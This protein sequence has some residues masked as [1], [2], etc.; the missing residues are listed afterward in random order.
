M[1]GKLPETD[2]S[3]RES[4]DGAS[5]RPRVFISYSHDSEPHAERVLQLGERLRRDG[6]D[7]C[8]DRYVSGTPPQGW[9]RWMLD[10]LDWASFVLVVCS[11]T[12]YRRFRGHEEQRGKGADWE[13]ALITSEIY[14]ARSDTKKFV[15]VLFEPGDRCIPEPIQGHTHH[16]LIT[17]LSYQAL[18]DFLLGQAGVVPGPLGELRRRPQRRGNPMAFREESAG[19]DV[20][21]SNNVAPSSAG[22]RRAAARHSG[23]GSAPYQ[24]LSGADAIREVLSNAQCEAWTELAFLGP[25]WGDHFTRQLVKAGW[26]HDRIFVVMEP[27]GDAVLERLLVPLPS[28]R[29]LTLSR[30]GLTL[31]RPA[32]EWI[33][34]WPSLTA[35]DVSYN[36]IGAEG[37][38]AI[39]SSFRN[40]TTLELQFNAIGAD[41]AKAIASFLH[42][43]AFLD[44][45]F[46]SVGSEGVKS[47][48]SSLHNLTSLNL[49]FNSVD[50]EGAK[51]IASSLRNLISLDLS[52]NTV[53]VEGARAIASSLRNLTSL[54][55][56]SN[57][58]GSDG[59][60]AIASSLPNLTS[61]GLSNNSV[62]SGGARAIASSLRNL[63]SLELSNNSIS[64]DGA[65]SI[66]SS[67][68]NLA[69]LNLSYNSVAS[70]GAKAIASSLQY[71]TSLNLSN[72]RVGFDGAKSIAS[73]LHNLTYLNLANNPITPDGAKT[74]ASSL[75][76]L[77]GL[78]LSHTGVGFDGAKAIASSLHNLTY[79]DLSSN[80]IGSDGAKAIASSLHGLTYLDLS[81]NSIGSDGAKAIA[82][83]LHDLI[84]LNL[85]NNSITSDGAKAIA[86]ELW[87]LYTLDLAENVL[88]DDAL[89]W[90]PALR[91]LVTLDLNGNNQ[92]T[93]RGVRQL[94]EGLEKDTAFAAQLSLL[95]LTGCQDFSSLI[96]E[97]VLKTSHFESIL[98][99]FRRRAE[100]QPLN[101]LKLLVL[102]DE[103]VGKTSLIRYLTKNQA[104]DPGEQKTPGIFMSEKIQVQKWTD[105][106]SPVA[107]NIW[108]FGGQE[109]MHGTHRYFLTRRSLYLLVLE[110]RREDSQ[111]DALSYWL[112]VIQNR[113]GESPV[114]VVINKAEPAHLYHPNEA[115]WRKDFPNIAGF[116]RITCN[117]DESSRASIQCLREA[118]VQLVSDDPRLAH[119]QDPI[120]TAWLRVKSKLEELARKRRTVDS[121][122]FMRLC[123]D[124]AEAGNLRIEEGA[125]QRTVLRLLHDLGV[126]VAHG[127]EANATAALREVTLLDPNWLTQAIYTIL[128]SGHLH[129]DHAVFRGSELQRFLDPV[130]YPPERYE[131]IT[132]MMVHPDIALCFELADERGKYLVPEALPKSGPERLWDER[133]ALRFRYRYELLPAGLIPRLIVEGHALLS[134]ERPTRWRSGVVFQRENCKALVEGNRDQRRVDILV[135]G[136]KRQR[137]ETLGVVRDLLKRVHGLHEALGEDA[138]VPL[139]DHPDLDVSYEH[140]LRLEDAEGPEHSWLPEK[141]QRKYTVME[142]LDGVRAEDDRPPLTRAPSTQGATQHRTTKAGR[143]LKWTLGLLG[144]AGA[145]SVV[146]LGLLTERAHPEAKPASV[147]PTPAGVGV[148]TAVVPAVAQ[149]ALATRQCAADSIKASGLPSDAQHTDLCR[150]SVSPDRVPGGA[151]ARVPAGK[152][153]E[154]YDGSR[155]GQVYWRVRPVTGGK[156]PECECTQAPG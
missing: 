143:V 86:H 40:L 95:N 79:L 92:F 134:P 34:D 71:L 57:T 123:I 155:N 14:H 17:E 66:A 127:L 76:N 70:G 31:S 22:G 49:P 7:V 106:R 50:V 8:L 115:Q 68:H 133:T 3:G 10:Q 65:K 18:Y 126:V 118:I 52:S 85:S 129:A 114:L 116:V 103:A 55:L 107:I 131:F 24:T 12:Y 119:V 69:R 44:L 151:G 156:G 1:Q 139:P 150:S 128:N 77:T 140:L 78:D 61:L 84:H 2:A 25:R 124:P 9:P 43:L 105:E 93:V 88:T 146:A 60:K 64:P 110:A 63:T 149:T 19:G 83:S 39:A 122:D 48:A 59:A 27:R 54:E 90:F 32:R 96:P 120:P 148:A 56:S 125:E 21:P 121:A 11:E 136:P 74:I 112:R 153:V 29:R 97:E 145:L 89:P 109:L 135:W 80:S 30:L 73:S 137:R 42:N 111:D 6:V 41:G 15:P 37:A 33:G 82:S 67:L 102:G 23:F 47:I 94:L 154:V 141:A 35:L 99:A 72:A 5:Q 81:N 53:D 4:V 38:R 75:Y 113:G 147:A 108:D 117:D 51:A 98:S 91:K 100:R 20:E 45:S 16:I 142:L 132:D 101:E 104:R 130:E 26:G 36:D 62:G 144:A 152:M 138:R 13:G 46:N 28:L 87:S 58:V